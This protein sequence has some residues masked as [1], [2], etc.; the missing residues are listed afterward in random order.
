MSRVVLVCGIGCSGTSATAGV[1]HKLGIPMGLE[2]HMGDHPKGF[3]LYEDSCFYDVWN[4]KGKFRF[5]YEQHRQESIFGIKN[6]IMGLHL[7]WVLPIIQYCGDDPYLVVSHRQLLDSV[8]GRVNGKCPPGQ[9]YDYRSSL[10]WALRATQLLYSQLLETDIPVFH[11]QFEGLLQDPKIHV[12]QIRD[13]VFDGMDIEP[14]SDQ[15]FEAI[16][17]I[18]TDKD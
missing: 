6:T 17:H 12:E 14:T 5:Q 11:I 10:E 9:Y 13:F 3:G 15:M 18:R 2:G 1:I 7:D 8:A 4:D 16:E